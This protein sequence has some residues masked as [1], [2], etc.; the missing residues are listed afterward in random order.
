MVRAKRGGWWF[1]VV[2]L[3]FFHL[4]CSS[5]IHCRA[6]DNNDGKQA[7]TIRKRAHGPDYSVEITYSNEK[8]D[9]ILFQDDE[10]RIPRLSEVVW[11]HK[12]VSVLVCDPAYRDI[13]LGYRADTN[14]F[15][16]EREAREYLRKGLLIRYAKIIAGPRKTH[17][18]EI[19]WACDSTSSAYSA[20]RELIGD[21]K[22]LPPLNLEK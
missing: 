17:K 5:E 1:V 18:D 20:F 16:S 12:S 21:V 8:G 2:S 9:K 14:T 7:V 19:D 13:I 6:Q 15:L 22:K 10:D 3:T 11:S 4:G